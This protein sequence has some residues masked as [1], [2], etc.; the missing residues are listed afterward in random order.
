MVAPAPARLAI[1]VLGLNVPL[2]AVRLLGVAELG[3]AATA[4]YFGGAALPA[5]VGVTYLSFAGFVILMLRSD[6]GAS[7]GCFGRS[8]TPPTWLHVALNVCSGAA[9]LAATG[10]DSLPTM[11]SDQPAAGLPMLGLVALGSYLVLLAFT[12]LPEALGPPTTAVAEFSLAG[13]RS[14]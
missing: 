3:L 14:N 2:W 6:Q 12:A 8:G 9:A 11:L 13:G 10:I 4:A 7:C 5:A 1:R